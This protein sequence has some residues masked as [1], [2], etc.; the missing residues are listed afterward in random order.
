MRAGEGGSVARLNGEDSPGWQTPLPFLL[1]VRGIER[2]GLDP[3]DDSLSPTHPPG[4][5]R[6]CAIRMQPEPP[7]NPAFVSRMTKALMDS[8]GPEWR[9]KLPSVPVVPVSAQKRWNPSSSENH[10]ETAKSKSKQIT[11]A[12]SRGELC[13]PPQFH[14]FPQPLCFE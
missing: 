13:L 3:E 12:K 8:L 11:A 7:C 14:G 1:R 5:V 10:K 4:V 2:D 6:G 9:L